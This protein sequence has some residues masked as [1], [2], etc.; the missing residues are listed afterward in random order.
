M[1][2]RNKPLGILWRID[3]WFYD[4]RFWGPAMLPW[5]YSSSLIRDFRFN[6]SSAREYMDIILVVFYSY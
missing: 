5:I 4:L 6:Y 3:F 1:Q 2:A